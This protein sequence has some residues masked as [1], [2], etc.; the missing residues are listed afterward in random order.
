MRIQFSLW[1]CPRLVTTSSLPTRAI[2]TGVLEQAKEDGDLDQTSV[3]AESKSCH[4]ASLPPPLEF[5]LGYVDLR[6]RRAIRSY[7]IRRNR[8]LALL[9]LSVLF[10]G[11]LFAA[12][13]ILITGS[14][15]RKE[16]P[17]TV[18]P[19][20]VALSFGFDR[21]PVTRL[22]TVETRATDNNGAQAQELSVRLVGDLRSAGKFPSEFPAEQISV[23]VN[24]V[25]ETRLSLTIT[26][27]PWTP[28]RVRSGIYSG[29]IQVRGPGIA[30]DIQ[31]IAWLRSRDYR[32]AW[33]AFGLLYCGAMLGLLVK[34]ITE[35]LTP[36]A[37]LIRQLSIL[38]RAIGY[39]DDG[40]TLPVSARIRIDD[41]EEQIVRG[42]YSQVEG[43]FKSFEEQKVKLA[44]ISWQFGALLDQLDQQDRLF[45]SRNVPELDRQLLEGV[46]EV[47][48][49]RIQEIQAMDWPK[50]E[51]EIVGELR[52]AMSAFAS[53]TALISAF[54]RNPHSA[55]R[56]HLLDV[57]QGYLPTTS[58]D[59]PSVPDDA[60]EEISESI[61]RAPDNWTGRSGL[62]GTL[63]RDPGR[64]SLLFRHARTIAAIVSVIVVSLV[65]LKTQYLD[66][67]NFDGSLTDWLGLGL[68]GTVVELSGVAVLDV[69]GRLG[70]NAASGPARQ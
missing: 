37:A 47:E 24:R 20:A 16:P 61:P 9:V 35:R 66:N 65:G 12:I 13:W 19:N 48:F 25:A 58:F 52:G 31:V 63:A 64:V 54:I 56:H 14:G 42:D 1:P 27:N 53:V 68:W 40:A 46:L 11:F 8:R 50:N 57:Q 43:S 21:D 4:I 45:S 7:L 15:F 51:S 29:T 18:P 22:V 67:Q 28:E 69:L 55:L 34:Y 59:I 32:W 36:Q 30:Q 23:G 62:F 41:L 17:P 10:Y 70:S 33:I 6:E 2:D 5:T 3:E 39:R 44:S 38:K 60:K 49:R 26:A